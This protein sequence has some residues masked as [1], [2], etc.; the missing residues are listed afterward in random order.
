MSTAC[1][2][3]WQLLRRMRGIKRAF[4]ERVFKGGEV[5]IKSRP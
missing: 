3:T 1:C 5:T 2:A 4:K